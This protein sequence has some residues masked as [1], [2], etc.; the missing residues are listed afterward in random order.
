MTGLGEREVLVE[1][2]SPVFARARAAAGFPV[3][4][5]GW[6]DDILDVHSGPEE[7][8]RAHV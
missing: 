8:G 2:G 1:E 5:T 6:K 3:V 7:I 4:V